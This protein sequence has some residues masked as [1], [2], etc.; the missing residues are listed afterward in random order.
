MALT[1]M[2]QITEILLNTPVLMIQVTRN[3]KTSTEKER[4]DNYTCR[5]KSAF[6]PTEQDEL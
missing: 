1:A 5:N 2:M 3:E 6:I 4:S